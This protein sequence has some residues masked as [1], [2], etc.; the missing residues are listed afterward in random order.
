MSSD[1]VRV[2]GLTIFRPIIYGN[3]AT[4]LAE[5]ERQTLPHADHTHKWTVAVRSAASAPGSDIVGGADDIAHFI[6][7]VS[8]KLHDTYP[9][10]SR[11]I[12]KPPFEVSETGWGEFEIQ[13]RITFVAES[14]EKAMT[15]YHHL[16][17]HP[18]AAAGEPEIPPLNVAIKMGPVHSWQ[19]DEVV[20]NDPFQNFLNILTAHP[21]T[22]LPKV[23]RKPVPF[24]LANP[25]SLEASRGGVPEFSQAMEKEELERVEEARKAV[26]AETDKWRNTLIEKEKELSELQKLVANQS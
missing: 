8:F 5:K 3:T 18:W 1:R 25:N 22:P 13:I 7:R 26:V 19:Y 24:H 10:P 21:P 20:F 17:L 23:R 11:N 9:N 14:G 4:V 2:R 15:L 6:K 16:K 12:D